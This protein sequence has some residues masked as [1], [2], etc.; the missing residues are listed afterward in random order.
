MGEHRNQLGQA[1]GAPMASWSPRP[2][3][4]HTPMVGRYCTVEKLDPELPP[5]PADEHPAAPRD[6]AAVLSVPFDT[7]K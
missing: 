4:P 3:P 2:R 5:L 7:A 1:I 6:A